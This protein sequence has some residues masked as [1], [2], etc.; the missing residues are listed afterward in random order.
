[1][2]E[3]LF[4][5][6][7]FLFFTSSYSQQFSDDT[8][9]LI[10]LNGFKWKQGSKKLSSGQFRK[11]IY[12]TPA[13]IP[14]HKKGRKNAVLTN[15]FLTGAGLFTISALTNDDPYLN[16]SPRPGPRFSFNILAATSFTASII[17]MR[18]ALKNK[19]KAVHLGN[20]DL[21]E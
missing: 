21:L 8:S 20:L 4:L 3:L 18:F 17:T 14:F 10:Y 6:I 5:L 7:A 9:R 2:K 16:F 19:G 1:M 12:K 13:A 15:I 11:E